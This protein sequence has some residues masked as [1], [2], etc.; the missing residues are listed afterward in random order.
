MKT[1]APERTRGTLRRWRTLLTA[2]TALALL[3][4]ASAAWAIDLPGVMA[5]LAQRKS[6]QAHFTEERHVSTLDSPLHSS[7]TLTFSA[8]D[9][10]ARHTLEPRPESAEVQGNALLLKRGG[11]T[12]RMALDAV[13]EL[14]ALL[15][16]L[17]GTLNGDAA[18]LQKH[19]RV[20]VSGSAAKWVMHL[21]PLDSRLAAQ[22]RAMEV[23]GQQSDLRSI[24]LDLTGGDSSLMLIDPPTALP[25]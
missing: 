4:G 1:Q 8:P 10:F 9:Q 3:T 2:L 13:P 23:V 11:R 12:R 20:E 17:R 21:T 5:L 14:S 7:G 15:G 18:A 19:F 24:E 16:A 6:G 25:R 22:V